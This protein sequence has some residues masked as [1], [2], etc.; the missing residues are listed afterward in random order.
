MISGYLKDLWSA[1]PYKAKW[2]IIAKAYSMI[3]DCVPKGKAPLD[4][5]LD[6][7]APIAGALSRERYMAVMGWSLRSAAG[8]SL[9]ERVFVP[10]AEDVPATYRTTMASPEQ[11]V[12]VCVKHG[13]VDAGSFKHASTT[14][15][16]LTM[17]SRPARDELVLSSA[18]PFAVDI[19]P[20]DD[21]ELQS[22][23]Y[24]SIDDQRSAQYEKLE[25]S[26]IAGMTGL[27]SPATHLK[28]SLHAG[29]YIS[30]QSAFD[31]AFVPGHDDTFISFNPLQGPIDAV[32]DISNPG[33]YLSDLPVSHLGD[34]DIDAFLH[35]N[36]FM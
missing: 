6:L 19:V 21:R 15:S 22:L 20:E 23:A 35:G 8:T 9:M 31:D 26:L 12:S 1:D 32:Y 17:A 13:F 30:S 2:A 27:N 7:V 36:A 16:Q 34:F 25:A 33:T 24:H 14:L 18:G 4:V 3:R 11:L 10:R 29:P 28:S 5:F